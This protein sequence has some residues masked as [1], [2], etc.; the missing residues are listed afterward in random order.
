MFLPI[1]ECYRVGFISNKQFNKKQHTEGK[2]WRE[3]QLK[4]QLQLFVPGSLVV[5]EQNRLQIFNIRARSACQT[6]SQ[7]FQ[8]NKTKDTLLLIF[9]FL[10]QFAQSKFASELLYLFSPTWLKVEVIIQLLFLFHLHRSYFSFVLF[11]N[12]SKFILNRPTS[13]VCFCEDLLGFG[14]RI[15]WKQSHIFV[16]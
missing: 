15:N 13:C 5:L 3:Q 9:I 1:C 12:A 10:R 2:M 16:C 11:Y 4:Q 6:I 8:F 14:T 7:V